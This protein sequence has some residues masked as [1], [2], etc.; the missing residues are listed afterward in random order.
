[1][2]VKSK[3]SEK[4]KHHEPFGYSF[5]LHSFECFLSTEYSQKWIVWQFEYGPEKL[6][7]KIKSIGIGRQMEVWDS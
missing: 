1:M 7:L 3:M 5:F 2:V 4:K 6:K